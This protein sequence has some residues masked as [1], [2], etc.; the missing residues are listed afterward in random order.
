M[1]SA[2]SAAPYLVS[3]LSNVM[4]GLSAFVGVNLV[5]V[6]IYGLKSK[7]EIWILLLIWY[8]F[9]L[10]AKLTPRCLSIM[11][12]T[13]SLLLKYYGMDPLHANCWLVLPAGAHRNIVTIGTTFIVPFLFA[14][15]STICSIRIVLFLN[16]HK[17][18]QTMFLT[19]EGDRHEST[20][21]VLKVLIF[22]ITSILLVLI[23]SCSVLLSDKPSAA[24]KENWTLRFTT[25]VVTSSS[26]IV[27]GLEL[28]LVDPTFNLRVIKSALRS[29]PGD[30]EDTTLVPQSI[31]SESSGCRPPQKFNRQP[32]QIEN[33]TS[34]EMDVLRAE[35]PPNRVV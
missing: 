11:A 35:T 9:R 4:S 20:F 19:S 32:L 5:C 3:I 14:T 31:S 2:N 13:P 26:P 34:V 16:E 6:L 22:P 10:S 28:L 8:V 33:R 15:C 27:L 29:Q 1:E 18:T 21:M 24:G 7:Y 17:K 30:R 25:A 12:P 23:L